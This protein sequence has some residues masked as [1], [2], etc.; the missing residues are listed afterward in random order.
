M[1]QLLQPCYNWEILKE[2][3][4]IQKE[5]M[6]S[7][8]VSFQ[9][10]IIENLPLDSQQWEEILELNIQVITNNSVKSEI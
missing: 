3:L 7:F 10:F 8:F 2:F 1:Y 6:A 5:K 4:D 9:L